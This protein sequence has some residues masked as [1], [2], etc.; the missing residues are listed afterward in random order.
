MRSEDKTNK[1]TKGGEKIKTSAE[2]KKAAEIL[3]GKYEREVN[4]ASDPSG[5]YVRHLTNFFFNSH[6]TGAAHED[7]IPICIG[8]QTSTGKTFCIIST[9]L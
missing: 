7:K 9:L 5:C 4:A 6:P 2:C 3:G 1:C 8:A